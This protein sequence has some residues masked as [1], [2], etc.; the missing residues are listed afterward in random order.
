MPWRLRGVPAGL[1]NSFATDPRQPTLAAVRAI[2]DGEALCRSSISP[3]PRLIDPATR[4]RR[5]TVD[6]GGARTGLP[7]RFGKTSGYSVFLRFIAE[8]RPFTDK[9]IALLQN[10]AAQAV[11]AMENARLFRRETARE[12]LE[13]QTATAEV[14]QRYQRL[15]RRSRTR[16]FEAIL[17]MAM[18]LCEACA[19]TLQHLPSDDG[20]YRC[21]VGVRSPIEPT[22]RSEQNTPL[23][24]GSPSIVGRAARSLRVGSDPSTAVERPR[25]STS[26]LKEDA[27][28]RQAPTII[29][30]AIAARGDADRHHL[31]WIA[32]PGLNRSRDK[33]IE[34]VRTFADQAV[35][36]I[37]NA[38]LLDEIRQRQHEL[39]VTFDN[40]ADGVAMFD[41]ALRLA[42]WNR[43]FQELL[44]LTDDYLA[45]RPSFRRVHPLPHRARRVW[46]DIDPEAEIARLRARLGDHYSFERT[47]PDGAVIEVR[48]NPMPD[49]GVVLIYQRHHRAQALRG[50][51]PRGARRRRGRLPRPAKPRRPV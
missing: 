3:I 39:R 1:P 34:L 51:D 17:E 36:A 43:N 28:A 37:E 46:R 14:L 35:I 18:R 38:R 47:R 45:E 22:A 16:C 33:Q 13:H 31:R 49:G 19:N 15:A 30:R 32:P 41:A 11:I 50:R 29:A 9:Q 7:W 23:A 26:A 42:A 40:M 25:L 24:A 21:A 4:L 48:H 44:D 20:Y 12:A 27:Q 10:F 5:A 8:V 6:L 2:V